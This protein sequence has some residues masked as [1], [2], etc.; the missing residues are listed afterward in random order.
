MQTQ[1]AIAPIVRLRS[2]NLGTS[3]S[4]FWIG[5]HCGSDFYYRICARFHDDRISKLGCGLS[6]TSFWIGETA[7]RAVFLAGVFI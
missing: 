2:S 3:N 6:K 1:T 7:A 4:S 5:A